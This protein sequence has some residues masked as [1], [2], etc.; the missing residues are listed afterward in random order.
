MRKTVLL[1]I[2]AMVVFPTLLLGQDVLEAPGPVPPSNVLGTRLI[3]WSEQQTPR[4]LAQPS[5]R[6]DQQNSYRSEP[7]VTRQV[8]GRPVQSFTGVIV[9]AGKNAYALK[10]ESGSA[11]QIIDRQIGRVYE[12]RR[13]RIAAEVDPQRN[14][15]RVDSVELLP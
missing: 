9:N 1:S 2:A 7:R 5:S 8:Q 3:V 4:P 6:P 12:G 13:V 15:L 11:Y 14:L 10:D